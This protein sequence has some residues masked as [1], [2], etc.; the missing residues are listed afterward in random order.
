MHYMCLIF[1]SRMTEGHLVIGRFCI[2]P[3]ST[4]LGEVGLD[5]ETSK[6]SKNGFCKVSLDH[7]Y[8]SEKTVTSIRKI[9]FFKVRSH[10]KWPAGIQRYYK[11]SEAE[12]FLGTEKKSMPL[13]VQ[14]PC[15]E[16]QRVSTTYYRTYFMLSFWVTENSGMLC[17]GF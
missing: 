9:P 15:L 2:H 13:R 3:C 8:T 10:Q 4:K 16:A 12:H 17:L 1:E 7:I 11:S 6:A 14:A 5:D